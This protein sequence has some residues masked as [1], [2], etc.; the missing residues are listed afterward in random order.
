[1]MAESATLPEAPPVTAA[2]RRLGETAGATS[3]GGL[4]VFGYGSLIW[5]PGFEHVDVHRARLHG[6]HRA[7]C[8]LSVR[9]RGTPDRPGLVLAL[10][11]GGSCGG[12]AFRVAPEAGAQTRAYLWGREMYTG[13]YRPL[14]VSVGLADGSR[15]RALTFAARRDHPQ[16]YQPPKDHDAHRASARLVLQGEGAMGTAL[17]YLRNV[18]CHLNECGIREGT[19]HRVL[20]LAEAD[21]T[22]VSS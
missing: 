13:A 9:N 22:T 8:M 20:T 19:L 6:W 14:E 7:L 1:M 10:D 5:E 18:V 3:D 12:L 16:Y 21:H 15:V 11:R 2:M 17:D 4:W